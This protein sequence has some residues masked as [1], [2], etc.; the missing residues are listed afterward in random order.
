MTVRHYYVY[1]VTNSANTVLY[2]GVTN[3][4]ARR[5]FEHKMHYGSQFTSKYN[6]NK[7]V[8]FEIFTDIKEAIK[9]EKQIKA[10][11][12]RKKVELIQS[13]NPKYEDLFNKI[14]F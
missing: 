13:M 14:I 2:T 1:I 6:I 7:L 3:H 11:S 5:I 10:G 9:R 12:R 8:Y 4:V